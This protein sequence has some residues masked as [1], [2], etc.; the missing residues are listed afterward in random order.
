MLRFKLCVA[1]ERIEI[2]NTSIYSAW[3]VSME[4]DI[5]FTVQ[6]RMI[7]F[8]EITNTLYVQI[9]TAHNADK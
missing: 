9:I 4:V 2:E 5:K 8:P 3:N 6:L 1:I 7:V